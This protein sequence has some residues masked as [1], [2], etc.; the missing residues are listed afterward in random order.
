MTRP[1]C[2]RP[3]LSSVYILSIQG[4]SSLR[5]TATLLLRCLM[6]TVRV[7]LRYVKC[8]APP[9]LLSQF[10]NRER[11][12]G[13]VKRPGPY[14]PV[15]LF[16]P[17]LSRSGQPAGSCRAICGLFRY[18]GP[19]YSRVGRLGDPR[20]LCGHTLPP[21]ATFLGIGLSRYL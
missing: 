15:W 8:N 10:T 11:A 18:Q 5:A 1:L 19:A 4:L 9:G 16:L 17:L 7:C 14:G 21:V 12:V 2:G 13:R 20:C 3:C 6:D